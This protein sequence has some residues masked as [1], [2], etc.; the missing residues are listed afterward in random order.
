MCHNCWQW[1]TEIKSEED[2]FFSLKS[3]CSS[4]RGPG[5]HHSSI[6]AHCQG[7]LCYANMSRASNGASDQS[8]SSRKALTIFF[9]LNFSSPHFSFSDF[10]FNIC[11]IPYRSFG[12]V[13]GVKVGEKQLVQKRRDIYSIFLKFLWRKFASRMLL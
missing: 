12:R 11:H 5:N 2:L 10:T 3:Y 4:Q 9:F 7:E 1:K 8:R 13:T 6:F